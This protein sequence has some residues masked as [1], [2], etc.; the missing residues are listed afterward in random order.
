M[1]LLMKFPQNSLIMYA[2]LQFVLSGYLD[3]FT[4]SL[5]QCIST[6]DLEACH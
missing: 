1:C 6:V 2:F 3:T 4:S 5:E